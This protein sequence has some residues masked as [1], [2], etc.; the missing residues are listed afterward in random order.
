MPKGNPNSYAGGGFIKSMRSAHDPHFKLEGR[1]ERLEKEIPVALAQ[2]HKTLSKSFGIQRKTL[3]RVID[4]EKKGGSGGGI[5]SGSIKGEKGDTGKTG[6]RGRRG[7][8]GKVKVTTG[9]GAD[10]ASGLSLIH[11]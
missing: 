11:I 8:G 4:L 6:R 5:R 9:A 7:W 10:G 1:V 3:M 2:L